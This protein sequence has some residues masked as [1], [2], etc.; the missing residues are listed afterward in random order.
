M[1]AQNVSSVVDQ[2]ALTMIAEVR[3]AIDTNVVACEGSHRDAS[4]L[5]ELAVLMREGANGAYNAWLRN[6]DNTASAR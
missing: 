6:C 2:A 3:A 5:G 1:T 4:A